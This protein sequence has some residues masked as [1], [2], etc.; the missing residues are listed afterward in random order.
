M[1]KTSSGFL[2]LFFSQSR[3]NGSRSFLSHGGEDE[4]RAWR[5][6]L[7]TQRLPQ[8]QLVYKIPLALS[9]GSSCKRMAHQLQ[10]STPHCC[11][12]HGRM[13]T[14]SVAIQTRRW[15][16]GLR[17]NIGKDR[18]RNRSLPDKSAGHLKP[19]TL[20][21][22]IRIFRIFRVFVSAF[23]AFSVFSLFGISS[24]PCFSGVRGTFRI[25]PV[26]GSNRWFRKSDRPA[27][28]WPALGDREKANR[29]APK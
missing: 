4:W 28:L 15:V 29:L 21:P 26:S 24:D 22:V 20:K 11:K 12:Y 25:F 17:P 8:L 19:V 7:L 1:L 6:N 18:S 27:L 9:V 14:V 23:S 5:R 3:L 13:I 10:D 16:S 2:V